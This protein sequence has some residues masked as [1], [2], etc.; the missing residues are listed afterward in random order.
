MIEVAA[1]LRVVRSSGAVV[2]NP[3]M[4]ERDTPKGKSASPAEPP[5]VHL[6]QP[7]V[8]LL[9]YVWVVWRG[10]TRLHPVCF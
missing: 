8:A 9:L 10:L 7:Y 4:S 2:G 5:P 6:T 1:R 3:A